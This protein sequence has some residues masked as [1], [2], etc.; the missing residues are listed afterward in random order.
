VP[1]II[2][3]L[4]N[5]CPGSP[6]ASAGAFP[7]PLVAS[8]FFRSLGLSVSPQGVG[9]SAQ[10]AWRPRV[11]NLNPAGASDN[12]PTR[13]TRPFAK[14]REYEDPDDSGEKGEKTR[15][16]FLKATCITDGL[17]VPVLDCDAR[18]NSRTAQSSRA[19]GVSLPS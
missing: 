15:V 3:F 9:V 12:S 14:R 1:T 10:R 16:C 19:S 8:G 7:A 13:L 11:C 4:A 2:S 17:M 6:R 18:W 5:E